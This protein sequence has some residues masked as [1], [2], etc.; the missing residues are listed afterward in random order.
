MIWAYLSMLVQRTHTLRSF[1]A[2]KLLQ[3]HAGTADKLLA[4]P[5][6]VQQMDHFKLV[7]MAAALFASDGFV[8]LASHG[9]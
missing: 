7:K 6:L 3:K 9:S 2:D 4:I 5:D 1:L 8:S